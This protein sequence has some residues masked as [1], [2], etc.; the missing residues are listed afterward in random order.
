M[1]S[2]PGPCGAYS[3]RHYPEIRVY[4]MKDGSFVG[5]LQPQWGLDYGSG[6]ALDIAQGSMSVHRLK[7]GRYVVFT[8]D[9][10]GGKDPYYQWKP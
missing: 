7:G 5:L 6:A 9:C 10:C 2:Q 8:E 1:H 3:R 4:R